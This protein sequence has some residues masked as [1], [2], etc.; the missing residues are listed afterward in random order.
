M[1]TGGKETYRTAGR[2]QVQRTVSFDDAIPESLLNV[3]FAPV[4]KTQN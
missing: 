1:H 2:P 4:L 3:V